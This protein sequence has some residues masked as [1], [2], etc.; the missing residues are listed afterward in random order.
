MLPKRSTE[1]QR[2]N[3]GAL[4]KITPHQEQEGQQP[5]EPGNDRVTKRPRDLGHEEI[6]LRA[7]SLWEKRG[8]P[9]GS[10]DEDWFC[11]EQELRAERAQSEAGGTAAKSRGPS[12]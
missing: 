9:I 7:Y 3:R 12:A 5:M 8:S 1:R 6:A 10:P 4:P 2:P 11:A